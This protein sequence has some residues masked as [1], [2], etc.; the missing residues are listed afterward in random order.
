MQC[1]RGDF[2]RIF[3]GHS[4]EQ[5]HGSVVEESHLQNYRPHGRSAT[6]FF[7]V[8][9]MDGNVGI[10]D[11]FDLEKQRI[12]IKNTFVISLDLFCFVFHFYSYFPEL[13]N[14]KLIL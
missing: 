11:S 9:S 14:Y 5:G 4:R 3:Q 13:I 6:R 12:K 8:D 2:A 7:Q 1:Y 10:V